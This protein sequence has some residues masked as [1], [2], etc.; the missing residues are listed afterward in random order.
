[1][2]YLLYG[3]YGQG[4]FG[5]DMLLQAMIEGIH[6]RDPDAFFAVH[7]S[8][9]VARYADDPRVQF[10][11]LSRHL[12]QVRRRPWRLM[13]YLAGFARWIARSDVLVIG[14]GTLFID[15]GRFN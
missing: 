7:S 1:M 12:D 15:K 2:R 11:A 10:T 3:Y 4:N 5:D 9:A 8:A 6:R 14:G 13:V